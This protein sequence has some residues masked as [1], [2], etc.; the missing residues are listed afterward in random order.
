MLLAGA[1]YAFA[2]SAALLALLAHQLLLLRR[3]LTSYE[4]RRGKA[5]PS[6]P[7][8]LGGGRLGEFLRETAPLSAGAAACLSSLGSALGWAGG[9]NRED[10]SD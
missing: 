4:A 9:A 8:S 1:A 10:R 6:P 5:P 3:G 2:V 7:P